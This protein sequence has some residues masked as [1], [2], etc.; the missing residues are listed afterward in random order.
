MS[1]YKWKDI[2][3]NG[4]TGGQTGNRQS[5]I[6]NGQKD[7]KKGIRTGGQTNRLSDIEVDKH[8]NRKIDRH[9]DRQR[10][11]KVG[12]L[13]FERTDR[14]TNYLFYM[15]IS[16]LVSSSTFTNLDIT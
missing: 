4:H 8:V 9:S 12:R 15:R 1:T 6:E 7:W 2:E 14:Y 3:I 10:N 5:E 13:K 16:L 11:L